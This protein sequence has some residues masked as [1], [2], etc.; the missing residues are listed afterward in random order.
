[1]LPSSLIESLGMLATGTGQ[2][3]LADGTVIDVYE[4]VTHVQWHGQAMPVLV[5]Q[6][7]DVSLMGMALME[8]SRL[9]MEVVPGGGILIER[10]D[11]TYS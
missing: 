3:H 1:M 7:T 8:G 2:A 4:F 5:L 6:S 9:T 11:E 10:L